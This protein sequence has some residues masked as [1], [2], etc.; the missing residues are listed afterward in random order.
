M[1]SD[2]RLV[3]TVHRE[4]IGVYSIRANL[5][6]FGGLAVFVYHPAMEGGNEPLWQG[7]NI[8]EAREFCREHA[9]NM[10]GD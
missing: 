1:K 2:P 8:L 3:K 6:R 10:S 4:V 9:R 5:T 7:E